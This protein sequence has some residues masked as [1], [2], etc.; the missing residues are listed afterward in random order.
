MER[1]G[2]D[3]KGSDLYAESSLLAHYIFAKDENWTMKNDS[4]K[5]N[6]KELKGT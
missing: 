1:I 6:A 5:E 4:M 3:C 2:K